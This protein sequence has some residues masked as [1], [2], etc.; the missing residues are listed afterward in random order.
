MLHDITKTNLA[1]RQLIETTDNPRHRF[2]LMAY[3]RHRNLEM[4]GRYEEIFAPDMMVEEPVYHLRAN[5]I[6]LKLEG[7]EAVKSLYRMWAATNQSIFYTE[8]EQLAVADNFVAS[9][10][11]AY[12]QVSGRSLFSNKVLSYLPRFL[13]KPLMRRALAAKTFKVDANSMYLYKNVYHMIW[14][15]DARGRLL[16]E[17]V[18]EPDPL[19]AEL[20][21]LDPAD[22]LTT[23]QSSRLLAPL[24]R[25]LPSFDEMVL[26][27]TAEHG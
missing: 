24:I 7:Q 22:V 15:Y 20:I 12:Q 4:A 16:G 2:L 3:D 11:V 6:S 23:A 17:D 10:S 26:G 8:T 19:K 25:P 27:K 1:V 13:S 18:W 14:P 9:V 21:K 5:E